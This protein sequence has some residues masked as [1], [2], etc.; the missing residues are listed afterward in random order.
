MSAKGKREAEARGAADEAEGVNH[1]KQ[2]P[3]EQP[4]HI[5]AMVPLGAIEVNAEENTRRLIG[6]VSELAASIKER[7]LLQ[8]LLVIK[9]A[10][11]QGEIT[12]DGETIIP[13]Q[14][15][16]LVL[17]Y[18]RYKALRL[19]Y[20]GIDWTEILVSVSVMAQDTDPADVLSANLVENMQREDLHAYDMARGF[21]RLAEE[22]KLS[23]HKIATRVSKSPGYVN[24]LMRAI[25]ELHPE[26]LERWEG[27]DPIVTPRVA[28]ELS[29]FPGEEQQ[30]RFAAIVASVASYQQSVTGEGGEDEGEEG[31][32]GKPKKPKKRAT[33][34]QGTDGLGRPLPTVQAELAQVLATGSGFAL[35]AT[36]RKQP[37]GAQSAFIAG[38]VAALHWTSGATQT[39]PVSG[40][41][42]QAGKRGRP[43]GKS[44]P[45]N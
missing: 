4:Q 6:D 3:T 26:I 30:R 1:G 20:A 21:L 23:G 33:K 22:H 27:H 9:L 14:R 2:G 37:R 18:R 24:N 38:L 17:G 15:Y 7:G 39:P 25:R 28:I 40:V 10:T 36:I 16:R 43:K 45:A 44:K 42:F 29:A 41:K 11:P 34:A 19:A 5:L 13:V 12:A 31:A 35:P 8:P 32:D